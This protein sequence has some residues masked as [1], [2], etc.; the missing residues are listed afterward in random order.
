[1][2]WTVVNKTA[3][4]KTM[5]EDPGAV[6]PSDI[7]TTGYDKIIFVNSNSAANAVVEV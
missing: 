2:A 7:D 5:V 4:I 3:Q 1:M 6:R